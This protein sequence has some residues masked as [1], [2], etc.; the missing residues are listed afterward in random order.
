MMKNIFIGC[1][2]FAFSEEDI[3]AL[4][5]PYGAVTSVEFKQDLEH[6]TFDTY[7]HVQIDTDDVDRLLNELDGQKAG[8]RVFRVNEVVTR[9]DS[10]ETHE[11]RPVES[12]SNPFA[13]KESYDG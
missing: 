5:V 3:R 4:F 7:A 13:C 10:F 11:M 1:M 6:A 8:S 2:P 9:R 12:T